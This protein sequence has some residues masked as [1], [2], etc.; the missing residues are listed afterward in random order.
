[1]IDYKYKVRYSS[2]FKK[3]LKKV[4]KQGKDIEKLLDIV[5]KLAAKEELDPKHKNHMLKDDKH[6]KNCGECHIE[7]DWLLIYQYNENEII[8]LLVDTGSHSQ[9]F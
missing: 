3:G 2:N 6:Y 1:M 4:T 8:L 7:P 9:L 5:D